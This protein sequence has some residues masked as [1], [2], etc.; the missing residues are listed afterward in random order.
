MPPFTPTSTP[1][2][3]AHLRAQGAAI[4]A[5]REHAGLSQPRAAAA[6]GVLTSTYR[7]W[8]RGVRACPAWIR[9]KIVVH[10][11]GDPTLLGPESGKCPHCGRPW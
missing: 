6:L 2:R 4:R 5:A 10:W 8:E 7:S 9:A 3:A 11:G 1:Q